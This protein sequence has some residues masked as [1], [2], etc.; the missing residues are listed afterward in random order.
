MHVA[1]LTSDHLLS[2][3]WKFTC[4]WLGSPTPNN[5][6]PNDVSWCSTTLVHLENALSVF[7]PFSVFPFS[8]CFLCGQPSVFFLSAFRYRLQPVFWDR[9]VFVRFL[10]RS[11]PVFVSEPSIELEYQMAPAGA[12]ISLPEGPGPL[13]SECRGKHSGDRF[14]PVFWTVFGVPFSGPFFFHFLVQR[15]PPPPRPENGN[16][17]KKL[18]MENKCSERFLGELRSWQCIIMTWLDPGPLCKWKST[19]KVL[20]DP[21]P[22]LAASATDLEHELYRL[23]RWV[24][25]HTIVM[26]QSD[27][28]TPQTITIYHMRI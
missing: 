3:S 2:P 17:W 21:P 22:P 20:A 28:S 8:D 16:K 24:P 9:L 12:I 14:Q 1:H 13:A 19:C 10:D 11:F 6:V 23:E 4:A 18:K 26:Y 25:R 27:T 5:D 7:P 15:H